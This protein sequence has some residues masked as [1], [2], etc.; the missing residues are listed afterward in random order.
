MSE[1]NIGTGK[2]ARETSADRDINDRFRDLLE[3]SPVPDREAMRNV[4]MY[5]NYIQW[6]EYLWMY[7]LYKKQL[8]VHGY[9]AE[10]GTL[11]GRNLAL[12]VAL[13]TLHEPFNHSRK[14]SAYSSTM[15]LSRKSC[16]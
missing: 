14:I 5:M 3:E 8:N 6:G 2:G 1:D 13:R 10:F 7:E 12:F 15:G 11:W 9:I 4:G 16:L